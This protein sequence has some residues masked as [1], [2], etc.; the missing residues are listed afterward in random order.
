M[1]QSLPSHPIGVF[2]SGVGGLTVVRALMDRLPFENIVYFG[3]TARVPYG[4]KSVSTIQHFTQQ[5]ADF[6]LQ[7]DV[8]LLIIACNTMAA[9][10]ADVVRAKSPVP[11][12]DVIEAGAKNAIARTRSGGIGVIGTPTTINSNA[13]ARAIHQLS[14]DK[15]V[16]S[17]ACPLFVPLVE[18][19]WLDHPVTRLTAQEYLKPVFVEQIDTL[20]LGCT[21]YPLLKPL[22]LDVT[23]DRMQLVDSALSIAD[24]TAE[25]LQAQG[26]ANTSRA[27]PD[28]RYVVTDVPVKFQTIGERF[29]GRSLNRIDRVEL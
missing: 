28:Y 4:V 7:Q 9:V 11:V 20:V 16:Y 29:L 21:H 3:D 24:Q 26:L 10:A 14:P 8:K 6:L 22:L 5:I 18:E 17:Q 15:H 23:G 13:Y 1:A 25:L 12:L 27:M 19:G 2:D